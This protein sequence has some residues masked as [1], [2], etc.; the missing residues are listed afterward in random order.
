MF[1]LFR[2]Q[3][4]RWLLILATLEFT[5][6]FACVYA[7][8][9]L[10]YV[11]DASTLAELVGL[12]WLRALLFA[13]VIVAGMA[14]MGL[15]QAHM[16]ETWFG[17][18]ARQAVAFVLGGVVL[19]V[20]YYLFPQ[21]YLGRGVFA[22]S[23]V[24]GFVLVAVFRVG[25]MRFIDIESLKRRVL[26]LGA[27]RRAA[28]IP[29]RLR[30]RSDRRGFVVV[31]FAPMGED[32]VVV[33]EEMVLTREGSLREWAQRLQINEIVVGPDDRRGGLPMD[34]LLEC[35]QAGMTVTDLATFFERES[36]KIKLS[37]ID[38]SWLVFSGGFDSSPLR[39]VMKRVF[40]IGT[41]LV[42]LALAWPFMLLVALAIR[43]ESGK[44]APILYRQ[45]RVGENGRV[46]A[47][48]KFRSMRTDAERDGVARWATRND[49]RVT[50]VGRIIR[51]TRLDE[52]P[53]LMNVLK[54]EM[55][56]VGPRPER[57]QFVAELASKI[58]YYNLRHCVKPGLAG[59][60]QLRYPYGASE[61][62][63]AEKL[64]YDLFYVKN[65][66][67]LLDFLIMIQ[68]VEVVLFG[69]GAR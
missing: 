17:L 37:L 25:F 39:L 9:H 7:A 8:S 40:D 43:L 51:K 68:T 38:P 10:R 58:R 12:L 1:A 46:F 14:S 48:T 36:G 59:W 16:R 2:Q 63:A 23:L 54:G 27:G 29:Q 19:V 33:P 60:A 22:L 11:A 31:G 57:P 45:E 18:I 15:Y 65:H 61:E 5:L 67:F 44:G 3:S 42:V 56:L 64:K 62:D 20:F 32:P 50:R 49:D 21:A 6:L 66:N 55:S 41:A 47:L 53:Q 28:L 69:R 30:R 26:V 35:K 34:E 4:T 24:F 52:L 13:G